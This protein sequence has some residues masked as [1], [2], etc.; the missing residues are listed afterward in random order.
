MSEATLSRRLVAKMGP[1]V[2]YWHC[3]ENK[4]AL[5]TPDVFYSA[6]GHLGCVELKHLH[7][8]PKRASTPL[9]FK[10]FTT[11]QVG[12]IEGFGKGNR[13]SFVLVQ[14]MTDHYLF[15]HAFARELQLE[16]PRIWWEKW[17]RGIWHGRLDYNQLAAIL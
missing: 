12:C 17:A 1:K 3:V 15:E 7:E 9:R 5:G 6:N 11:D 10:H 2:H 4:V 16:Q 13:F 14:V 8:Y